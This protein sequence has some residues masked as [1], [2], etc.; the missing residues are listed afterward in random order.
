MLFR[1]AL[2]DCPLILPF[3]AEGRRSSYHLFPIQV[4]SS[5]I[6]RHELFDRLRAKGL[7][8]NVHY[9]PVHTQ[10]YYQARGFSV[11]GLSRS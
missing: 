3:Q 5:R 11:G 6:S 9:I 2:Q 4:V 10:P 7:G 8:V 1:S